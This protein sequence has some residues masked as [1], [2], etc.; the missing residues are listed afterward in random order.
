[1]TITVKVNGTE[2][3]LAHKGCSGFAKSTLP[4]V[5]KTPSPGGPVPVPYP[6]IISMASDLVKGTTTV[7]ADGNMIAIKGS[8]LSRCS[9]D[10][11]GT[12]GGVKSST[13]MKE[14]TWILYS[15]TVKIEGKN[16]CR[17]GDKL[18]M[19]HSNTAC[20]GGWT[21]LPVI[22]TE[23][24]PEEKVACA[25]WCCDQV[26]YRQ[27]KG[28][29]QKID[30]QRLANK[31]HSCVHHALKAN[32]GDKVVSQPRFGKSGD[33]RA[34]DS[35][36]AKATKRRGNRK[37]R[38]K[39]GV[40][41]DVAWMTPDVL[42]LTDPPKIIDAK[43]PCPETDSINSELNRKDG[44]I[45][46]NGRQSLGSGAGAG[47]TSKELDLYPELE[48]KGQPIGDNVE[49]MSPETA[50]AQKGAACTCDDKRAGTK[51]SP[52]KN[53]APKPKP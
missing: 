13:N 10:E 48:Y 25:I 16:A 9:G 24:S 50:E 5:C 22:P 47:V 40:L 33:L 43:F 27:T 29:N 15:P 2:T 26:T 23:L 31:K 34:P 4:D 37:P 12:A 36:L 39:A 28:D 18:F 7:K 17:L 42:V 8:E 6:I 3:S 51:E 35:T 11:A 1:M 19:N 46:M 32:G 44:R 41:N 21:E 20:L 52:P 14:A 38:N 49:T 30:C 45:V 53:M